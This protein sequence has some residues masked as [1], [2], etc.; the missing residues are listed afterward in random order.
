M[1]R[2]Q[3]AKKADILLNGRH[4]SE[5][6]DNGQ[7]GYVFRPASASQRTPSGG[8]GD[9]REEPLWPSGYCGLYR[10]LPLGGSAGRGTGVRFPGVASLLG[11]ARTAG[12]PGRPKR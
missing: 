3:L 1:T 10:P 8:S 4:E 5:K 11:R 6:R 12:P 7:R 9:E 2:I